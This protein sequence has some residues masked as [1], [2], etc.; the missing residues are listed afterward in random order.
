[1]PAYD[2]SLF[3]PPAPVA[4]V[5]LRNPEN[6]AILSDVPMLLDMG[7]DVTLIPQT[8]VNLIG[9]SI[10]PNEDY[11]LMGFNGSRS[12]AHA[13]QLDLL[14]L[15]RAFKGRFLLINQ[16]CGILGRDILNHLSLLFDGPQLIWDEHRLFVK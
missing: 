12:F 9:V 13:A 5:A 7:A 16:E 1:M 10:T 6:N 3:T 8:S 2:S 4:R 14:F 15:R 11:E